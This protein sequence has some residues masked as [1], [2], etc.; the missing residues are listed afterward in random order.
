MKNER[1]IVILA[2]TIAAVAVSVAAIAA[3]ALSSLVAS[4]PPR[5][6]TSDDVSFDVFTD[7]TEYAPGEVVHITAVLHNNAS[8]PVTVTHGDS[9]GDR[10]FIEDANG[11]IV[12]VDPPVE[13]N[14]LQVIVQT[15]LA[16]GETRTSHVDWDQTDLAHGPV[17]GNQSY[18][19]HYWAGVVNLSIEGDTWI[20]I[21]AATGA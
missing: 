3:L 13:T 12:W 18:R 7:K 9:C 5:T 4:I 16:P 11:T 17:P 10:T 2:V 15:T 8:V 19:I 20:H 1:L 6:G 14:C 21:R